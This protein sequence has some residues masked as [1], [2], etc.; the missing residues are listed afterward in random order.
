MGR[1]AF[2][3]CTQI[4]MNVGRDGVIARPR[5]NVNSMTSRLQSASHQAT[6]SFTASDMLRISSS[7][8]RMRIISE[9]TCCENTADAQSQGKRPARNNRI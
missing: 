2:V 5:D 8:S 1:T 7:L 4:L 9:Y 6:L 3:M